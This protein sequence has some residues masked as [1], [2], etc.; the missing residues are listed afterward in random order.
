[1]LHGFIDWHRQSPSHGLLLQFWVKWNQNQVKCCRTK[2]CWNPPGGEGV[3][4]PPTKRV[5]TGTVRANNLPSPLYWPL[6]NS[7]LRVEV[8]RGRGMW[9]LRKKG[10]RLAPRSVLGGTPPRWWGALRLEKIFVGKYFLLSQFKPSK[11]SEG[12]VRIS[13]P[14]PPSGTERPPARINVALLRMNGSDDGDEMEK[15]RGGVRTQNKIR[16][17]KK[18]LQRKGFT[19]QKRLNL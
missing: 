17:R 11:R 6:S 4:P 10:W 19:K 14:Q 9:K 12:S 16:T 3:Q 2:C 8:N 15:D 18:Y 1:M 13:V 7:L 5:V